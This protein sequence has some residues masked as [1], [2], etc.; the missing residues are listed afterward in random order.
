[1]DNIIILHNLDAVHGR[2]ELS[3]EEYGVLVIKDI[4][5]D[6]VKD[7]RFLPLELYP[8][9]NFIEGYC[10]NKGYTLKD[11]LEDDTTNTV[12]ALVRTS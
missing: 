1:M 8:F 6:F 7:V 4:N 2:K 5:H 3:M 11:I 9:N 12:R 10:K